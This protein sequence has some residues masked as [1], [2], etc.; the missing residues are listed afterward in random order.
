MYIDMYFSKKGQHVIVVSV[1]IYGQS[2][3]INELLLI[4]HWHIKNIIAALGLHGSKMFSSN[5]LSH[6]DA[7]IVVFFVL[8]GLESNGS[9]NETCSAFVVLFFFSSSETLS[10]PSAIQLFHI[11]LS[12]FFLALG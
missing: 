1:V 7:F 3:K 11:P 2:L 10:L 4:L 12:L 5:L 8:H 9:L 6:C